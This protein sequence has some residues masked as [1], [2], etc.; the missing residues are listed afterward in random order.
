MGANQFSFEM[1]VVGAGEQSIKPNPPFSVETGYY[2]TGLFDNGNY[3]PAKASEWF[4]A[5]ITAKDANGKFLAST[6]RIGTG[7]V[8]RAGNYAY[9]VVIP[10]DL[11]S[12]GKVDIADLAIMK[13]ATL[14]SYT[15]SDIQ[16][17][18]CGVTGTDTAPGIVKL[19]QLKRYILGKNTNTNLIK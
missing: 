9:T 5:S 13:R 18:A 19:A 1:N 15:L 16:K 17:K 8:I 3:T 4:S 2:I 11:N 6:D 10:C 7:T 12:D 14:K